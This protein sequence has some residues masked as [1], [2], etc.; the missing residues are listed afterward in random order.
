MESTGSSTAVSRTHRFRVGRWALTAIPVG[1]LPEPH[2]TL[3][4][5]KMAELRI[6]SGILAVSGSFFCFPVLAAHLR[7]YR[8]FRVSA[9]G[10]GLM[11]NVSWDPSE[12]RGALLT[13]K[14]AVFKIRSGIFRDSWVGLL[15]FFPPAHSAVGSRIYNCR[16]RR[17]GSVAAP[18]ERLPGPP[19]IPTGRYG[20]VQWRDFE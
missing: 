9:F 13:G 11:R 14:M 6:E 15:F 7:R 1:R 16:V 3:R 4:S 20:S 19:R 12:P 17:G 8:V 2:G 18:A 5:G 10:F